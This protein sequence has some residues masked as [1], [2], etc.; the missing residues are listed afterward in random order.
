M[1]TFQAWKLPYI[2]TRF[3]RF[4]LPSSTCSLPPVA[5]SALQ[6]L[7]RSF[8]MATPMTTPM[9]SPVRLSP[10]VQRIQ[11]SSPYTDIY[12]DAPITPLRA[13]ENV[14][15][16]QNVFSHAHPEKK[17]W[18]TTG[19]W[20]ARHMNDKAP[21]TLWD[22]KHRKFRWPSKK[23]LSWIR[24]KFGDGN[25]SFNGWLMCFETDSPP[26]PIQLTLGTLPIIF[27][28][29][30]EKFFDPV[31]ES[32]Y[33]NY[34]VPD[35]CPTLQWLKMAHPTN[36]Q[37]VAVLE[38]I[39]PIAHVKA[40]IFLPIWTIFELET[41]D[42]R[43]YK[44]CSLPG[45]VA[46]R[47]A[48]Y[49]HDNSPVLGPMKSLTRPR[50]IDPSQESA[51]EMQDNSNYLR[52]SILTPGCR[53][54]SGFGL[55]GTPN[56][57]SNAAT[58]CGIKIRNI[59]G[60]EVLTVSNHGFLASNE[61]Y[62]PFITGGDLIGQVVDSRSELDIALVKLTPV[63]SSKFTNSCYFQAQPPS[64]LLEKSQITLGS[65]HEVDGMSSGLFSIMNAGVALMKPVRP[66]GHPEIYFSQWNVRLVNFMFGKVDQEISDGVCGAP[67]VDADT[68]G[69]AGFFHQANGFWGY[70]A[71]LDDLVA[72]GWEVV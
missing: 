69:V 15:H 72:E 42:G 27:V 50:L 39:A 3:P 28:R 61:V 31:P 70:S 35:P 48:L 2:L 30:G 4:I 34:R 38:A 59:A 22:E 20:G 11:Q 33:S 41:G 45:V 13:R 21:F 29:P 65:W 49:H 40:A 19:G 1:C 67:I 37:M 43:S 18:E 57:S 10:H 62:H 58:T 25:V 14:E 44:K 47:T 12:T 26:K 68:G 56:E 9:P 6:L 16:L 53:I 52:H 63:S 55:P 71:V 46:G 17:R 32:G 8:I 51:S 5:A 7:Q 60:E 66:I 36:S 24:E 64:R 54:E 23:E